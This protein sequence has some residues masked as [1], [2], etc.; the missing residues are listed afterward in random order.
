MRKVFFKTPPTEIPKEI[1][2]KLSDWFRLFT[3]T[4]L[5]QIDSNWF[6]FG[7][8]KSASFRI[9]IMVIKHGNGDYRNVDVC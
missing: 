1:T 2:W 4:W 8:S 3:V 6:T 9:G 5:D 7:E